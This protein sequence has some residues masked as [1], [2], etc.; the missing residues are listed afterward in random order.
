MVSP[1]QQFWQNRSVLITGHTGFKGAWLSI[2]L[3]KLGAKISGYALDPPDELSLF[4]SAAEKVICNDIRQD[5]NDLVHLKAALNQSKPSIVIHLAAQSLVRQSYIDPIAT[6]TTNVIG[7]IKLLEAIRMTDSVRAAV[8]ITSDKCYENKSGRWSYREDDSLGG[9]DPYSSSKA[10]AEL[11]TSAYRNS[12][13]ISSNEGPAVAT[14]RAGNVI[15]GGDWAVDRILPDSIKAFVKGE[16]ILVRNPMSTRP[17]QHVLDPLCGYLLLAERLTEGDARTEFSEGWNFGPT[18]D[19]VIPVSE[20]IEKII[21]LWGP[22][23]SWKPNDDE[24]PY[25]ENHLKIDSL[26]ARTRLGWKSRLSIDEVLA[27]TIDWY[28]RHE[29]GEQ[30][31]NLCNEQIERYESINCRKRADAK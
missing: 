3:K 4:K 5:I 31:S 22:G 10:C 16:P 27:W 15:G 12:F 30:A 20:L 7:T 9:F 14:A 21:K 8:I 2:W 23:A 17:W 26:K 11:V 18:E 29:I 1:N 28:K 13:F 25:E 19:E 24:Q 6:Y